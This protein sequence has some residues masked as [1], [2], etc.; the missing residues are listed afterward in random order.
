VLLQDTPPKE[1]VSR[2]RAIVAERGA[3]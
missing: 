3:R 1:I 2:L